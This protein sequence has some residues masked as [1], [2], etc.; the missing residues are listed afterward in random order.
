MKHIM[1]VFGTRPEAIKMAPVVNAL[2]QREELRCTVCVTGQHREM[3]SQVLEAFELEPDYSLSIMR[4]GQT[5]TDV[6]SRVLKSFGDVLESD[7]PDLVLVHG[8]TT[9]AFAAG[10]A[11]FYHQIEV[12]HVEA[13]LRTRN[14][15]SPFPEE[16][17]RQAVGI[18]SRYHFAPTD[19]ARANLLAEGKL[20]ETITVTGNTAIDALATTVSAAWSHEILDWAQGSRL[21]LVTAHRRESL[22]TQMVGMFRAIRRIV[23]TFEDTKVVFPVHLN[24]KVHEIAARE[25]GGHKR[26]RLIDPLGVI[27]FHNLLAHSHF[28]LTDSGGVQEEAPSLGKPVLVMRESTERP[29]GVVAGTLKVVGTSPE[30]I[31]AEASR[32]LIDTGEY[33]RMSSAPNPYGDGKASQRIAS[34]IAGCSV[35]P[36][37]NHH[38]VSACPTLAIHT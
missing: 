20:D 35:A 14:L 18:L 16:F 30:R 17:N 11:S 2:R 6:T 10:L 1:V 34:V 37:M 13:G 33:S 7:K 27:D 8:D 25:L 29:E 26:I 38:E 24:P 23:E 15:L 19:G 32:L 36:A 5:L 31:F 28:V 3:L 4:S 12:G 9:T 22:G 21:L